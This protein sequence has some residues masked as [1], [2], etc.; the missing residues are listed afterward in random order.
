MSTE[1]F[2]YF[3]LVSEAVH[4]VIVKLL[5]HV[6]GQEATFRLHVDFLDSSTRRCLL[7]THL[8]SSGTST[9]SSLERL[10]AKCCWL[11]LGPLGALQ[12]TRATQSSRWHFGFFL[13]F[14][15]RNHIE[16][17]L[18]RVLVAIGSLSV[19]FVCCRG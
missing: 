3:E 8:Y 18:E 12:A 4:A 17:V 2:F 15:F 16:V 13:R 6:L 19:V 5:H 10:K 14:F 11:D 1:N 7:G 9:L